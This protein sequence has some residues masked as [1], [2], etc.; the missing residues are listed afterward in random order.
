[1]DRV[2]VEWLEKLGTFLYF[3]TLG[4]FAAVIGYLV[5]VAKEEGYSFSVLL[6]FISAAAGFYLGM[7]FGVL[8]PTTWESRDAVVL[9]VG[10]TGVKGFELVASAY[11][12][13]LP[14]WMKKKD[15]E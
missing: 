9:L 13:L 5:Q 14:G 2:P 6:L 3:G 4:A 12:E 11:K 15:R 10:A 7:V 1:M 8:S